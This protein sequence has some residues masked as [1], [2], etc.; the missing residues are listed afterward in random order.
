M[1]LLFMMLTLN[2]CC[3]SMIIYLNENFKSVPTDSDWG[4]LASDGL[5][6]ISPSKVKD[7]MGDQMNT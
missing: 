3:L 2:Q 6:F 7:K 5:A 4:V 1:Q